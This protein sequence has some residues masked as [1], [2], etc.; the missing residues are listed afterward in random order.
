MAITIL[1]G[2]AARSDSPDKRAAS[3][4]TEATRSAPAILPNHPRTR[5]EFRVAF[6]AVVADKNIESAMALVNADRVATSRLS[7]TREWFEDIFSWRNVEVE[8]REITT[9]YKPFEHDDTILALNLDPLFEVNVTGDPPG[10]YKYAQTSH[11]VGSK[12]GAMFITL[13]ARLE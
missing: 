8:I 5:E 13:H 3:A 9:K 11:P 7:G 12:D 2:C 6:I 4:S 1:L 10:N